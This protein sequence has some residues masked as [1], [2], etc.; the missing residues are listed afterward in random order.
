[1]IAML[2]SGMRDKDPICVVVLGCKANARLLSRR[3]RCAGARRAKLGYDQTLLTSAVIVKAS[4]VRAGC[5]ICALRL[6]VICWYMMSAGAFDSRTGQASR[7]VQRR[8]VLVWQASAASGTLPR[9]TLHAGR[10][11]LF[12]SLACRWLVK[13]YTSLASGHLCAGYLYQHAS[14]PTTFTNSDLEQTAYSL[15]RPLFR[16]CTH[17]MQ[18]P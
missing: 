12:V 11:R 4:T 7:P 6:V 8:V 9:W 10:C 17:L 15:P 14:A 18:R 16:Y 2:I 1:M 5:G 3:V 13:R